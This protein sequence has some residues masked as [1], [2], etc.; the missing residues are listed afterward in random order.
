[1]PWEEV[2]EFRTHCYLRHFNDCY[3][4]PLLCRS[5]NDARTFSALCA[6]EVVRESLPLHISDV[7]VLK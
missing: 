4:V 5:S 1:M 7:S 6:P 2:G 3:S